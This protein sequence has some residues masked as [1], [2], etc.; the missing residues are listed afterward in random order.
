MSDRFIDSNNLL[1]N[2]LSNAGSGSINSFSSSVSSALVSMLSNPDD[3]VNFGF[4]YTQGDISP[5]R[6]YRQKQLE[7][8]AAARFGKNNRIRFNGEMYVPTGNRTNANIAGIASIE[9]PLIKAKV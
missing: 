6:L 5:D 8:S 3:A 2:S 7:L 4:Q 1:N 9:F